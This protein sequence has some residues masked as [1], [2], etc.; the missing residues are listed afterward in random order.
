MNGFA[1]PLAAFT[2]IN[3]SLLVAMFWHAWDDDIPERAAMT[4]AVTCPLAGLFF[5]I[6]LAPLALVLGAVSV[7]A[8]C[9]LAYWYLASPS[10]DGGEEAEEPVQPG[11]GPTDDVEPPRDDDPD[12][13]ID[14]DQFDR[15]RAGWERLPERV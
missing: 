10:D 9:S 11:P 1:L 8:L 7:L 4:W 14:W 12:H 5:G 15:E 13:T 2:V 6:G 3:I